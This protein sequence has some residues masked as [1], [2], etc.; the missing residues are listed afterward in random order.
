MDSALYSSP[1]TS[2]FC[3]TQDSSRSWQ[4]SRS[5]GSEPLTL[6]LMWA[7]FS[8]ASPVLASRSRATTSFRAEVDELARITMRVMPSWF[9]PSTNLSNRTS[10]GNC[11]GAVSAEI[12]C[13]DEFPFSFNPAFSCATPSTVTVASIQF[14]VWFEV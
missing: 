6:R 5:T 9:A 13:R 4:V 10:H 2:K 7:A 3:A 11:C 8:L 14:L 12:P 1:A